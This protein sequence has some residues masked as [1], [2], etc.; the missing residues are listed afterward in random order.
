MA[1]FTFYDDNF[2]QTGSSRSVL[3]LLR[4]LIFFLARIGDGVVLI[5]TGVFFLLKIALSI[6]RSALTQLTKIII[7]RASIPHP[8]TTH[9]QTLAKQ[10]QKKSSPS[11]ATTFLFFIHLI[12]SLKKFGHSIRLYLTTRLSKKHAA[13]PDVPITPTAHVR[14]TPPPLFTGFITGATLVVVFV[15]VPYNIHV[16]VSQLPHPRLLSQRIIPVTTQIFDR[17]GTLLYEIHGDEDRKLVPLENIPT[18]VQQ[19]TIAIEDRQFYSHPGFSLTAIARAA[20][21]TF[22]YHRTQGGSTITQQLIK[23]AL[24]TPEISYLRKV[25]EVILA[26]WTERIYS[27]DQILEMYFNQVPY[28]GTAWG[29]EAASHM[30]FDKSVSE[31]TLA[32][33]AYIAGLPAA[34]SL[35]SPYGTR[36]DLGRQRQKEV[37]SR[38]VEE[39]FIS[40]DQ[41]QQAFGESLAIKPNIVDIKAPHFVMYVKEL[42]ANTYGERLLNQGG[43]KIITTLDLPLQ[44]KAQE[45]VSTTV[46]ALERLRVGNGAVI[47]TDPKTGDILAMVGSKNYFDPQFGSVNVALSPRQPGS[48]IKV[49]TYAAALQQGL[50]ART[51][52]DDTPVSF[53]I[54]GQSAYAPV[55]YDGR[56]HGPVTLRTALANSYN[57]PAVK[58]LNR[59]GVKSLVD[60]GRKMGITTWNDDSRFG[61]SLTLGGGEVTLLDMATVYGTLANQGKRV[62]VS[63]ILSITDFSGK[64]Y[65]EKKESPSTQIIPE[66]VSFIMS[67]ILS[68]NQ[69]RSPAFGLRSDLFIPE[70][71]VAVKTGTTNDKR[72]NWTI[73]YTPSIV[74]G[75]WVGNNDNSPMDPLLSSGITGASPIWNQIMKEVLTDKPNEVFVK[76]DS[77]VSIPCGAKNEYF[78]KGTEPKGGCRPIASPGPSVSP[79]PTTPPRKNR[80]T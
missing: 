26:F 22:V 52:I 25:R 76:P 16:F 20:R 70:K 41:A 40:E 75:V 77:V 59:L 5:G 56:F 37:L 79:S 72:D 34:P 71:S 62:D 7:K 23:T 58:V 6:F 45:I 44:E 27:K 39:N 66:A 48:S 61:L 46:N 1:S 3:R 53:A 17:N 51:I 14:L 65:F 78:I 30:Y 28:G 36:P 49:I 4:F 64:V 74:V 38:M 13:S 73:G 50:T 11:T 35:Y 54:P 47:V 43:L 10:P 18:L 57:V 19:A 60:L 42:V 63:P 15:F 29:I 80:R 55:N 68:D 2:D 21:E 67:D 31:L 9:F 12:K 8:S 69:A 33:A 32:E 24:L